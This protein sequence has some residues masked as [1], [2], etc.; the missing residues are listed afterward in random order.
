MAARLIRIIATALL[1]LAIL[2]VGGVGLALLA[3]NPDA[4]KSVLIASVHQRYH[5][6]LELPGT[7]RLRL[8]PPFT[9]QT[10][11]MRLSE[12]DG[13]TPFA[14]ASDMR[15]HLNALALLRRRF[16]VDGIA[17]DAPRLELRRDAQG[18][19]N[20]ADLLAAPGSRMPALDIHALSV[21]GGDIILRDAARG[22]DGRLSDVDG[23]ATGIGRHGWHA[24]MLRGRAS[25]VSPGAVA[26]FDLQGQL[27][28]DSATGVSLRNLLL[29]SDGQMLGDAHLL[30]NVRAQLHWDPGPAPSLLI[31]DLQL[32]AQGRTH[33]GRPLQ[34]R[35][36]EPLLQWSA[37]RAHVAALRGEAL[38][39]AAPRTLHVELRGGAGDGPDNDLQLPELRLQLSRT[40]P[41]PLGLALQL[42]AHVDLPDGTVRIDALQAHATW[43]RPP[44]AGQWLAQGTG[45]Y[46][47]G[48]GL[49]LRLQAGQE[50]SPVQLDVLHDVSGWQLHAQAQ[51]LD[52]GA[53]PDA[54]SWQRTR[55]W[56]RELP[57]GSL[58]LQVGSLQWGPLRL[59]QLQ[60]QAHDD[61]SALVLDSLQAQ[62]WS[63]TLQA[64]GSA[65]WAAPRAALRLSLADVSMGPLLQ[66]LV[67]HAALQGSAKLQAQWQ[68][69]AGGGAQPQGAVGSA[70]LRMTRGELRG[71]DLRDAG[72]GLARPPGP[73]GPPPSA[74]AFE[75]LEASA[76]IARG[77][78]TLDALQLRTA[79]GTW[80]GSGAV[81]LARLGL[82]LRL[83]P[84][85]VG[86]AARERAPAAQLLIGGSASQPSYRWSSAQ[87]TQDS[88]GPGG[89]HSPK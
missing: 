50:A 86:G 81:D 67:G 42:G 7:L 51:S 12:A 56:L 15:L 27:H 48:K 77:V 29:R 6:T 87:I 57:A 85:P 5:R 9:L 34:I 1:A 70:T 4:F 71:V 88:P 17:F 54:A 69:Q 53:A 80:Q 79:S 60:A 32:R 11:P 46:S 26:S 73:H 55:A 33:D 28:A 10:G 83:A 63:G 43:G 68:W 31:Q 3:F 62:A 13:H 89:L 14:Q 47:A 61:A 37:G 78:A 84:A 16:V 25:L 24:L 65:A 66:S 74:T 58:R 49:R 20:F 38:V 21:Q 8:F 40:A 23:R 39:G 45:R 22:L 76:T 30:S 59:S 72:R 35:L 64:D 2:L 19:W 36:D 52:L 82:R 44:R 41:Q 75:T 18:H